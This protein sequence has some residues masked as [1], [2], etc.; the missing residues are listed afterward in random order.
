MF[1][2]GE[3]YFSEPP[4][5]DR[6]TLKR[7]AAF[8]SALRSLE[9]PGVKAIENTSRLAR[10]VGSNETAFE[11]VIG[12]IFRHIKTWAGEKQLAMWYVLHKLCR[13]DRDK[14]ALIAQKYVLEVASEC[15]P[16]EDMAQKY[17][18]LV[19]NWDKIFQAHVIDAVW[20]GKKER[21]WAIQHPEEVERR[22]REE[23]A[24][25]LVEELRQQDETGLDD[26]GQPCMD[27]LQG[28]CSW[29]DACKQLHPPGLE[30][31]LPPECRLGDWKC[32]SCG[33][34]N[35]HFRRRCSNCVSEKPQY[36]KLQVQPPEEK[37]LS[38]PEEFPAL[39]E[40][41]GF[42]PCREDECVQYWTKRLLNVATTKWLDDRRRQYVEKII[43]KD[44]SS[45]S[46]NW[47]V[48]TPPEDNEQP[49]AILPQKRQR[50]DDKVINIPEGSSPGV[51]V[52]LV[53][54][55]IAERGAHDPLF[56]R[57]L[58][59]LTKE[60]Q[61]LV[62][63]SEVLS[64]PQ[65]VA[66]MTTCRLVFSSWNVSPQQALHPAVPF[67]QELGALRSFAWIGD[68]HAAPVLSMIRAVSG[69]R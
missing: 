27:Y 1:G 66:V 57:M 48:V 29:G 12:A 10:D 67:F 68:A 35:R 41:F 32:G 34:I 25:W 31:S 47:N 49:L 11:L 46:R 33:V 3:E 20:A 4:P 14:Y 44:T 8:C 2:G 13:D 6:D 23:E 50:T 17:E 40:Q 55:A 16:W 30:G 56:G 51:A 45:S 36:R 61:S 53:S 38:A 22:Y 62:K 21:L 28:K 64:P 65:S 59:Q 15:I 43:R 42:D 54:T 58:Y 9:K 39:V 19:S 69:K 7:Y 60:I 24:E 18:Q 26:Y 63:S 37:L 52:A 5:I